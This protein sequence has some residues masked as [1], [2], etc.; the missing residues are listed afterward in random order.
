[1]EIEDPIQLRA[2]K[3]AMVLDDYKDEIPT[4]LLEEKY[5]INIG[6]LTP[7]VTRLG[8]V[9]WLFN[10]LAKLA[11][12]HKRTPLIPRIQ[13]LQDRI[14]YGVKEERLPLINIRYVSRERAIALQNAGFQT[15]ESVAIADL[16]ALQEVKVKGF[17]LGN[18]AERIQKDATRYLKKGKDP[19]HQY[20]PDSTRFPETKIPKKKKMKPPSKYKQRKLFYYD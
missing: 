11:V 8:F 9:P 12:Y 1:M 17:K 2:I 15:V 5:N 7:I 3:T 18:W 19:A 10:A 6:D 14:T 16:S 4:R 13:V 20:S